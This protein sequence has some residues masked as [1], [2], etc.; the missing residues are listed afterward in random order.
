MNRADERGG[1]TI[2]ITL[3]TPLLLLFML[4]VILAGR[5]V[6]TKLDVDAA[7]NDA[8]RAASLERTV[9]AAQATA[10]RTIAANVS[11]GTKGCRKVTASV[12]ASSFRPG[13]TVVVD[14]TCVVDLGDLTM[15][16]LPGTQQ[17]H[18]HAVEPLDTY[19]AV[20]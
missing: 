1:A 20:G 10:D 16:R 2:E 12:D 19:R 7:A 9:A 11:E 13:G 4:L 17:I 14:V 18:G 6:S 5:T 3:L 8:A 15:L